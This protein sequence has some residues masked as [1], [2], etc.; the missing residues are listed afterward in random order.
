MIY[1]NL[2]GYVTMKNVKVLVGALAICAAAP[3]AFAHQYFDEPYLGVEVM[4]NNQDYKAGYGKNV[5]KKNT[6]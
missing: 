5:F 3:A 1:L 2:Q 6:Q 4:Q